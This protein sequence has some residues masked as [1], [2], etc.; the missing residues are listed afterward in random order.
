M[1]RIA[2]IIRSDQGDLLVLPED[3]HFE[4][5][6]VLVR[7]EGLRLVLEPI[8]PNQWPEGFWEIFT[9]DPDFDIPEPLPTETFDLDE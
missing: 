3:C 6:E 4:S 5:G 1:I 7:K 8:T 2:R 9:P